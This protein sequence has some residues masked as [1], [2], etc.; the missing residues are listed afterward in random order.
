MSQL[1]EY[2]QKILSM[3]SQL[4]LDGEYT[5]ARKVLTLR[6]VFLDLKIKHF[7]D[8]HKFHSNIK[9]VFIALDLEIQKKLKKVLV[10]KKLEDFHIRRRI[11]EKLGDLKKYYGENSALF[12]VRLKKESVFMDKKLCT[13]P[14]ILKLC[15]NKQVSP[16]DKCEIQKKILIPSSNP[17]P[18][19]GFLA[20]NIC[21]QLHEF[22]DDFEFSQFKDLY[23]DLCLSKRTCF[24]VYP[25]AF[26]NLECYL[27]KVKMTTKLFLK[28]SLQLLNAVC[29]LHKN[30]IVHRNLKGDNILIDHY[31][32]VLVTGFK[33]HLNGNDM[34]FGSNPL[35]NADK[36]D[37]FSI[38]YVMYEMLGGGDPFGKVK[39]KNRKQK[40]YVDLKEIHNCVITT[41]IA[42][43][44]KNILKCD[45][46][47]RW[48]CYKAF[49]VIKEISS[50]ILDNNSYYQKKCEEYQ[51]LL[52][53][54]EKK[55]T[56]IIIRS[57]NDFTNI[58]LK[59]NTL[60]KEVAMLKR[61][62]F[63]KQ[64]VIDIFQKKLLILAKK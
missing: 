30:K 37:L 8:N 44:L 39:P 22:I 55:L 23:E 64:N 47:E 62:N 59:N 38:G 13:Y 61:E 4:M 19:N 34:N 24:F 1:S 10:G 48:S 9:D 29:E 32:A 60:M 31:G 7:S 51:L 45:P 33:H 26:S 18:Q 27:K 63:Q 52:K 58:R 11:G 2:Q 16:L 50:K 5:E 12:E 17:L 46:K 25:I 56:K 57:A 42:E 53:K 28:L 20:K 35:E 49:R 41:Q 6:P 40:N 3:I 36:E 15:F 14:L 54:E 43:L 21:N